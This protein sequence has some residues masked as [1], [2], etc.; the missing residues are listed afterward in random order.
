MWDYRT[1]TPLQRSP[2]LAGQKFF[3]KEEAAEFEKRNTGSSL[4]AFSWWQEKL[5][6]TDDRRT[7]LIVDPPFE[8]NYFFGAVGRNYDVA[9]DGQLF[10]VNALVEDSAS[11]AITWVL[12]WTAELEQ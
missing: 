2:E 10:L 6:L 3:T 11:R 1:I 9:P 12:N 7:S 8:T 4:P 5:E